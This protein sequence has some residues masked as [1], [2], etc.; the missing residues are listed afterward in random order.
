M[1]IIAEVSFVMVLVSKNPAWQRSRLCR[2]HRSKVKIVCLLHNEES[3]RGRIFLIQLLG[4]VETQTI[5]YTK[6][7]STMI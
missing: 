4:G 6:N 1:S 7:S 3:R 2:N 5:P